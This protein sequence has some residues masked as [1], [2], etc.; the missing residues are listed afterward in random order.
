MTVTNTHS[1]ALHSMQKSHSMQ[2]NHNLIRSPKPLKLMGSTMLMIHKFMITT[3]R[4]TN[5][6]MGMVKTHTGLSPE[7]HSTAQKMITEN[8]TN[9]VGK[10]K[11]IT[12]MIVLSGMRGVK[13]TITI[14]GDC[15]ASGI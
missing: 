15:V 5:P 2:K 3:I 14:C 13:K 9:M 11:I 6:L 10:K 4:L 8:K 7:L 12:L 1:R